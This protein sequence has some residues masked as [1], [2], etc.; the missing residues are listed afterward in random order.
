MTYC[1]YVATSPDPQDPELALRE[2]ETLRSRERVV[3]ERLDPYSA[4]YFP[5]EPRTEQLAALLR[6]ERGVETIVRARTWG[7]VKERCHD[8]TDDADE[9]LNQW[10]DRQA[11]TARKP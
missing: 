9:A 2:A 8:A 5:R 3:N 6:Q 1:A 4:R 7:L 10:R 11:T